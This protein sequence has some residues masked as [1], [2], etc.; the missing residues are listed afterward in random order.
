MSGDMRHENGNIAVISDHVS[1]TVIKFKRYECVIDKNERILIVGREE[2]GKT[3]EHYQDREILDSLLNLAYNM[4]IS[5]TEEHAIRETIKW[6]NKYG[7]PM[8]K[9]KR[10]QAQYAPNTNHIFFDY[11]C[12]ELEMQDLYTAF[13]L[14]GELFGVNIGSDTEKVKITLEKATEELKISEFDMLVRT[15][16]WHALNFIDG[17]PYLHTY[18]DDY[19]EMAKYQ[20]MLLVISPNGYGIKRCKCCGNLF[21]CDRANRQYCSYCNPGKYYAQEKRKQK[22]LLAKEAATDG[23]GEKADT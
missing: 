9:S 7:L 16:C 5:K 8:L 2:T 21:A 13:S 4:L 19:I 10:W 15:E 1:T 17:N 11:G 12:F 20:L 6:C 22:K 3:E 18:F 23:N 14:A